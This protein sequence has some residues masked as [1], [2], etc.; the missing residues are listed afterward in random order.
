MERFHV[1]ND[2]AIILRKKGVYRQVKV[3]RRGR[4]LFAAHGA[5]F[6]GLRANGGTTVPHISWI[7]IDAGDVAT[8]PLGV[9]LVAAKKAKGKK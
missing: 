6:I 3:Y 1:I 9:L 4:E 5:G 8:G 2:A 7:E